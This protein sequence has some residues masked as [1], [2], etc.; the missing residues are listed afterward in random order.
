MTDRP[1]SILIT[2]GDLKIR[3]LRDLGNDYLLLASWLSDH[4]VLAWYQGR[5]RPLDLPGAVNRFF[6]RLQP[7]LLV[8]METEIWPN[9]YHGCGAR[10]IPLVLISARIS[11]KSVKSYR[12]LLPLFRETLSH[13]IV[14]AAQ[15]RAD[16]VRFLSL[17]AAPERTRVTGNIKF[18]F[19]VQPE[20]AGQGEAFDRRIV[21]QVDEHGD[22]AQ[23]AGTGEFVLEELGIGV[24]HAHGGE[25]QREQ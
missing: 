23:H 18:D 1:A 24:R 19:R 3:P 6:D 5:D 25:D 22:V 17:G 8:I 9:L 7:R 16:A 21:R 11:P 20:V 12:K 14:I 13:G 15:T 2:D 4:R 10:N